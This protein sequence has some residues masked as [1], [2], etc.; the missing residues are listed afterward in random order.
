MSFSMHSADMISRVGDSHYLSVLVFSWNTITFVSDWSSFVV[1]YVFKI[2]KMMKIIIKECF[3]NS[4]TQRS[5]SWRIQISLKNSFLC[6][7]KPET[8]HK[9]KFH[10]CFAN[11]GR[12][13]FGVCKTLHKPV[14][15]VALID[16]TFRRVTS[17]DVTVAVPIY[18]MILIFSLLIRRNWEHTGMNIN[19]ILFRNAGIV[20]YQR[21]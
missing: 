19:Y 5:E 2:E 11:S 8:K 9:W 18:F 16:Q 10:N 7:N 14:A 1:E 20:R 12:C 21:I 13:V 15:F 17:R 6:I 3:L 4:Y